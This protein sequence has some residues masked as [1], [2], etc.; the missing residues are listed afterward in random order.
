[1]LS[2]QSPRPTSPARKCSFG[3]ACPRRRSIRGWRRGLPPASRRSRPRRRRAWA[4]SARPVRGSRPPPPAPSGSPSV[5]P[6]RAPQGPCGGCRDCS[7]TAPVH[8]VVRAAVAVLAAHGVGTAA[9]AAFQQARGQV[10][11]MV[12]AVLA[13]TSAFR[14]AAMTVARFAASSPCRSFTACQGAS[15]TTRNSGTSLTIHASGGLSRDPLPVPGVP[16]VAEPVPDQAADVEVRCRRARCP[17]SRGPGWWDRSR[18]SPTG[19][20]CRRRRGSA[21]QAPR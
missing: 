21:R 3:A 14:T 1:M 5:P 8:D 4:R 12:G 19:R 9:D 20:R 18:A 17:A 15:S 10:A 6:A 16:D 13:L 2:P 11:G 7:R